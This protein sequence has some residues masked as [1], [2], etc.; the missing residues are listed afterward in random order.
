MIK[1]SNIEE[2]KELEKFLLE[3]YDVD[4]IN[5]IP[6]TEKDLLKRYQQYSD[7]LY[8]YVRLTVN[9][10]LHAINNEIRALFGHLSEYRVSE[11]SPGKVDLEKAYGHFRRLNLDALKILC[12]EFDNSLSKILQK[13]CKYDYRSVNANYLHNFGQQYIDAKNSYIEAQKAE[14]VGSDSY[15]H[16]IIAL[17]HDAAKKYIYLKKFYQDNKKEIQRTQRKIIVRK[18][19]LA[20]M[21]IFGIVVSLINMF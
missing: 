13:Q 1:K 19:L 20:L 18:A 16:N 14:C 21:T 17:Y 12:N 2:I 3:A 10:F 5:T 11:T 8:Q 7:V 9:H 6:Y 4:V 15:A